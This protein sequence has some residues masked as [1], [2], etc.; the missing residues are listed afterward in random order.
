MAKAKRRSSH[1]GLW[2]LMAQKLTDFLLVTHGPAGFFSSTSPYN[3]AKPDDRLKD[4]PQ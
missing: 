1:H 3:V 2:C 4:G